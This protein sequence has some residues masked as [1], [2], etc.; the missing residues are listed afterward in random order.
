MHL[1]IITSSYPGSSADSKNAGVFVRDFAH[2]IAAEGIDV[3]ILTPAP[4]STFDG[5]VRVRRIPWLGNESSLTHLNPRNPINL[6]RF[7]SLLASGVRTALRWSNAE[8]VDHILAMWAVPS[9]II[10]SAV[11]ARLGVPY[12]VWALGSDIWKIRDYPLGT[13]VL[14]RVLRGAERLYADGM[15]L[16]GDVEQIAGRDCSFLATSRILPPSTGPTVPTLPD[17]KTNYL[18]VARFHRNKGVDVLLNAIALIPEHERATMRFWIFGGGPEEAALRDLV[19]RLRLESQVLLAGYLSAAELA[20]WLDAADCLI[21]P[22]RIESIPLILSDAAQSR[23]PVITTNVGDMGGLVESFHNG[24]SVPP[25]APAELARAI[26]RFRDADAR[27]FIEGSAALADHLSLDRSIRQIQ[28][29]LAME[30]ADH[31]SARVPYA[32]VRH[33]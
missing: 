27:P 29:D 26:V 33:R 11:H 24:L 10:A 19:R 20:S 6:V 28:E 17:G 14:R 31:E 16:A 13:P 7:A 9:G 23:C 5:S 3:S 4:A 15:V 2:G 12:S 1:C 30:Q 32:E 25:E 21:I 18:C 22:S 8:H